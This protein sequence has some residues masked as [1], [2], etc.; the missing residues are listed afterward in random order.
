MESSRVTGFVQHRFKFNR[1]KEINLQYSTDSN[2]NLDTIFNSQDYFTATIGA[3]ANYW[4]FNNQTVFSPR[5]NIKWR[6]AFTNLKIT[7]S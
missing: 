7:K 1:S 2:F 6:P 5:I 3:R 4:T